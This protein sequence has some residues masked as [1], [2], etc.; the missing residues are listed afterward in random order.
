[1]LSRPDGVIGSISMYSACASP[2]S[3]MMT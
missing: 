3:R 2:G 1:M